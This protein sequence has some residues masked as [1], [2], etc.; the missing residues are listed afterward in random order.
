M[1][2]ITIR[3]KFCKLTKLTVAITL[4]ASGIE[5]TEC[6][7]NGLV[8]NSRGQTAMGAFLSVRD[9]SALFGLLADNTEDIILKA[10][11]S[12]SGWTNG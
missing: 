1:K 6:Q 10:D 5:N 7:R 9:G 12:A 11:C 2:T 4:S 8:A 3:C